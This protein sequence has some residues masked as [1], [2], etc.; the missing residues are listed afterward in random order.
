MVN[1][2]K[3]FEH[4][5]EHAEIS[6]EEIETTNYL[7]DLFEKEGFK[8]VRFK[9][10]PGFYVEIGQGSP[11]IGVRADM[12]ALWQEVHGE[13]KANHSCG[14]DA[15]MTIV[16]GLMMKLKEDNHQVGT[17]RAVFQPAEELGNGSLSV[18]KEGAVDD[19]DYFY[20][21]HVRPKDETT[22]PNCATGIQHGSAVFVRGKIS[23][24]DHHGA[25][26]HKGINAIEVATSIVNH[27]NQIHTD[28]HIAATAKMT[29]LHAG[30]DNF[31]IIP[32]SA[33]FGLDLRAQTNEMMDLLQTKVKGILTH[34]ST[35]YDVKIDFEFDDYVPAAVINEDAEKLM[36]E[37]IEKATG[38]EALPRIITPGADDFHFY[39]IER[40]HLKATMLGLG[41]DV[42]PG[43]HDP[44]MEFNHDAIQ[45]GIDVLY[46]T[47]QATIRYENS[48]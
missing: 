37:G 25:R 29:N 39:T 4:L 32:G 28:P 13:M 15:H 48:K 45:I 44:Y 34:L 3:V 41:A 2:N 12:D 31:N 24:A 19:L 42:T 26:P 22:F 43:L 47:C 40:P 16:T 7:I 11:K 8:P 5:H 14:H 38:K 30:T 1:L 23:G 9:D 35:L 46:E 33:S 21:V 27:L 20:G 17:I 36:K 6:F 10:C 18:V